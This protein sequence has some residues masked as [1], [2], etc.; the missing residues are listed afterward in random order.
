MNNPRCTCD[1]NTWNK[2]GKVHSGN[3]ILSNRKQGSIG[4][5]QRN[6]RGKIKSRYIEIRKPVNVKTQQ[7]KKEYWNNFTTEM[8][9]DLY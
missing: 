8:E 9:R 7:P 6:E 4:K 2:K 3:Q 5:T 1:I